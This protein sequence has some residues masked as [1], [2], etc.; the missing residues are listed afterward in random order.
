[1]YFKAYFLLV[2]TI[3]LIF[4]GKFKAHSK[5]CQTH[6]HTHTPLKFTSVPRKDNI[7]KHY[8]NQENRLKV[9]GR[10]LPKKAKNA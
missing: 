7:E 10:E 1:M 2:T 9:F 8:N 6:T 3:M 5:V 4:T